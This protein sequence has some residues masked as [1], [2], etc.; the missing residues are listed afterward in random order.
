MSDLSVV[1]RDSKLVVDSRLVADTLGIQHR[2]LLA[3]L[4]KYEEE[5]VRE[6][7]SPLAF[8]T[9]EFK[10]KQGN[11]SVERWAWLDEEW[12]SYAMTL[13]R[14]TP[15]VRAAK[16]N[17]VKAFSK[18]KK[19]LLEPRPVQDAE[20]LDKVVDDFL[21]IIREAFN[22][23]GEQFIRIKEQSVTQQRKL[24]KA[25]LSDP[26]AIYEVALEAL[27]K[28][29]HTVTHQSS[30]VTNHSQSAIASLRERLLERLENTSAL[31]VRYK[32]LP[33]K[34]KHNPS[35]WVHPYLKK[36]GN[37]EYPLV[38]GK[39]DPDGLDD[40]YWVYRWAEKSP[41]ARRKNGHIHRAIQLKRH[42]VKP[43]QFA[44]DCG[45]SR[46]KIVEQLKKIKAGVSER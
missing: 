44:I 9:R 20:S 19:L 14:N 8:E 42:Q 4:E 34:V 17:L 5:A 18:A 16:R 43:V 11:T 29:D 46:E 28:V 10:T 37:V 41:Q 39:R 25:K 32:E 1:Q 35:G 24:L 27:N 6:G 33:A 36:V 12:A 26:D 21:A 38:K 7:F 15:E 22:F 45:A 30:K 2:N 13:S 23:A 31:V 3:N 40:W